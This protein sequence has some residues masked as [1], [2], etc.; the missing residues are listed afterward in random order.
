[1]SSPAY[2]SGDRRILAKGEE[3]GGKE[4]EEGGEEE[5]GK[6]GEEGGGEEEEGGEE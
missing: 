2:R 6:E 3:E 4:G 5:E 1:M